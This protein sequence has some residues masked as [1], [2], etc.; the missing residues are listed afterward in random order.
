MTS[1]VPRQTNISIL[2]NNIFQTIKYVMDE[3]NPETYDMWLC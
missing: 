1:D 3:S 2:Y